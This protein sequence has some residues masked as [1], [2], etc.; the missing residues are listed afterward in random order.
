[1]C[2]HNVFPFDQAA[3]LDGRYSPGVRPLIALA[4]TLAPF[5]QAADD[6]LARLAGLHVSASS[7]RRVTEAAGRALHERHQAG[8]AV[9]PPAPDRWDLRLV[10]ELGRRQSEKVLYLGVDAFAVPIVTH[11]GQTT[12][13]RMLYVGLLYD[14]AKRHTVY[15]SDY[16]LDA[17][18]SL[19]RRYA[20]GLG[21]GRDR[22]VAVVALTDGGR[23]LETA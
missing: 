13:W 18:A 12:E 2:R 23:G 4:S 11:A 14:P 22:G 16:D 6:V 17:V 10:D 5:R 9:V 1:H 7:C 3:G 19:L 21:L 8:Q 15:V 20:V